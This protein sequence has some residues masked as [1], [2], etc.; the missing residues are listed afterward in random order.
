MVVHNQ[1]PDPLSPVVIAYQWVARITTL[2]LVMVVPGVI[3]YWVDGWLG[4]KALVTLL[5]FALGGSYALW[6]L[7]KMTQPPRRPDAGSNSADDQGPRG[8]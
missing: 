8:T 6:Q 3:G 4:T 5:G 2:A 7:L 1:P